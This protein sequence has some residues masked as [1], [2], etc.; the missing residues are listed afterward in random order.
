MSLQPYDWLREHLIVF[1]M[2]CLLVPPGDRK[3]TLSPLQPTEVQRRGK[4]DFQKVFAQLR[5]EAK[6]VVDIYDVQ[7]PSSHGNP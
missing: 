6:H 4:L 2:I 3:T 7:M 5:D 1:G